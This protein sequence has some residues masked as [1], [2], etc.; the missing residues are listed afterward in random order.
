[1]VI[2]SR[3]RQGGSVKGL[4]GWRRN[5]ISRACKWLA[6]VLLLGTAR[7]LSDP[8]SGFFVVRRSF[9]ASSDLRPVGYKIGLEILVRLRPRQVAEAPYEF[10]VRHSG[11]SK[12]SLREG[13]VFLVHLLR[14]LREVP[15]SGRV[16]KFGFVGLLGAAVNLGLLYLLGVTLGLYEGLAWF[17]AVEGSILHNFAWH[18]LFT[19]SDRRQAGGFA[20]IRDAVAFHLAVAGT[21]LINGLI[22]AAL[23]L[24]GAPLLLAGGTGIAGGTV[25][26]FI[27]AD[28]WVFRPIR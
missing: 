2:A 12:A 4:E 24:V 7:R 19:W 10:A 5:A 25:F 14:L 21:T 28:R 13:I 17:L 22:F 11:R 27:T 8:L 18:E 6:H 1:M 15:Q 9:V 23:S 20:L 26:N 16:W 3:Y